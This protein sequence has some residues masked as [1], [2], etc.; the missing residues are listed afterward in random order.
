MPILLQS[1]T[2]IGAA[3]CV[4]FNAVLLVDGVQQT[5]AIL[6][7]EFESPITAEDKAAYLRLWARYQRSKG[8]TLAQMVGQTVV[9][10][11]A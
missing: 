5:I 10:D 3:P 2:R 7:T 6:S 8:K 11:I 9:G 1:A 4:H